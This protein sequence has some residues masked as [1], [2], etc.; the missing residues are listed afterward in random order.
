MR[1]DSE[2]RRGW[3]TGLA[4]DAWSRAAHWRARA[5]EIRDQAGMMQHH[6]ARHALE[7][8]A[9]FCDRIADRVEQRCAASGRSDEAHLTR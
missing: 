7:Q 1:I 3:E 2:E 6:S 8:F 5:E 9:G 4:A